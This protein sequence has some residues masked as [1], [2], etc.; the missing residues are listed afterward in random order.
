MGLFTRD[1]KVENAVQVNEVSK[2][3]VFL[4]GWDGLWQPHKKGFKPF[5]KIYLQMALNTLYDGVS[6]ITIESQNHSDNIVVRNICDFVDKNSTLLVSQWINLGFMVVFY[7]NNLDY[8]IPNTSDIKYD[9][10][11]RVINKNAVV[12]YS[13]LFQTDKLSYMQVVLPLLGLIDKLGNTTNETTNT[14]GVLPIISGN[15]IPAN[16]RYKEE[17]A[18]TMSKNYGWN[19]DQM[20]YFLSQSEIKVD[21]INLHIK[22]LE[23]RD[24]LSDSFK[25]L[26]NYFGVPVDLVIGNSTYANV[27]SARVFFYESTVRKYAEALLKVAQA[28]LVESPVLVPKSAINYKLNNVSGLETT[29]SD[30]CNEINSYIDTLIKLRDAGV[31]GV[32]DELVKV[33]K[34]I[35]KDYELV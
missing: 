13:P 10:Y 12:V 31:V 17:L 22:D 4:C 26:L 27:E 2:N 6:N 8:W 11:R 18:N 24:N 15:S 9:Q 16:P 21:E 25:Y 7:N 1:K 28:L 35:K 14:M 20:R 34:N 5:G 3:P 33:Y 23:L 29:L 32:E 19:D 30:K